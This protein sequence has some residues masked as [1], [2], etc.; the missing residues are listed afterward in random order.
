[1]PFHFNHLTKLVALCNEL[2]TTHLKPMKPIKTTEELI[3]ALKSEREACI[4]GQRTFPLPANAEEVV[5]EMAGS[6][7]ALLGAEGMIQIAN[8]HDFREQVQAYQLEHQVSGL[9]IKTIEIDGKTYRFPSVEDQL[10]LLDSDLQ[11]LAAAKDRAVEVFL[12]YCRNNL[13]YC[14]FDYYHTANDGEWD[15]QTTPEY[16]AHVAEWCEWADIKQHDKHSL[17]IFLGWGNPLDAWYSSDK[18]GSGC[19]TFEAQIACSC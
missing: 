2:L 15:I 8:Y 17:M 12:E 10:D 19:M 11:V 18:K 4:N 6:L 1:M 13:V 7:G 3:K 14:S 9:T 16:I 5:A